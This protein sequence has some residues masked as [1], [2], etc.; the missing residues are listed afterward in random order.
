MKGPAGVHGTFAGAASALT[1]CRGAS[2]E[3]VSRI[4]KPTVCLSF[5]LKGKLF[6]GSL[7][8]LL[9]LK[10][11]GGLSNRWIS[12]D[13]PGHRR[14][15]RDNPQGTIATRCFAGAVFGFRASRTARLD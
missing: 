7:S 4:V 6:L 5:E 10:A 13:M 11:L 14:D 9:T 15:T 8:G 12:Q 2:M 3:R 1:G